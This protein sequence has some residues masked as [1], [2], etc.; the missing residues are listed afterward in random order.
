MGLTIILGVVIGS[1][2]N[3][4]VNDGRNFAR[5]ALEFL[6]W[7]IFW[8]LL[9]A[10]ITWGISQVVAQTM[11]KDSFVL[12]DRQIEELQEIKPDVYV[13]TGIQHNTRSADYATVTVVVEGKQYTVMLDNAKI[14]LN[15]SEH[16]METR[17][18]DFKSP[19]LKWLFFDPERQ[20]HDIYTPQSSLGGAFIIK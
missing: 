16:M 17:S 11:N 13:V 6:G 7:L 15:S 1:I 2:F 10:F 5:R 14:T 4:K 19:I 9:S 3:S 18:Y 8:T 12:K 20:E